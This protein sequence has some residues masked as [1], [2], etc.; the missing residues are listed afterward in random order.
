MNEYIAEGVHY[1]ANLKDC[2]VKIF[3]DAHMTESIL[4]TVAE[5][6]NATALDFSFRAF[7]PFGVTAAMIL[8][9]SHITIHSYY[10]GNMDGIGDLFADVFTCGSSTTPELGINH[11]IKICKPKQHTTSFIVRKT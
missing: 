1:F 4:T 2:N 3:E 7:K 8:S 5:L 6:S 10:D 11:L 9:E